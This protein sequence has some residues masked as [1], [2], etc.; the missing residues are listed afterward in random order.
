[1]KFK[2]YMLYILYVVL[3]YILVLFI[4]WS[5]TLSRNYIKM[6]FEINILYSI[7]PIFISIILGVLMSIEYLFKQFKKNGAWKVNLNKLIFIVIPLLLLSFSLN[8]YYLNI[9]PNLSTIL[10]NLNSSI[11]SYLIFGILCGYNL[12]T[13]FYKIKNANC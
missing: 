1:M 4:N 11:P 5:D 2:K 10:I 3:I 9:F 6:N 7:I 8:I 13:S 12:A